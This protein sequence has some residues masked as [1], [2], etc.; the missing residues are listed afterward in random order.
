MKLTRP[1]LRIF[2]FFE[3]ETPIAWRQTGDTE[4]TDPYGGTFSREE[5]EGFN[6]FV[7]GDLYHV[8]VNGRRVDAR[9]TVREES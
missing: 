3:R 9:L 8:V 1:I 7:R 2:A 4:W 5:Q 6:K